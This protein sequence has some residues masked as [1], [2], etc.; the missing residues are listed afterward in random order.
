MKNVKFVML[1]LI[2]ALAL[3]L[4]ACG[5]STPKETHIYDNAKIVDVMNGPGTSKIGESSVIKAASSDITIEVLEDWYYN[6]VKTHNYNSCVIVYSDNEGMGVF[7]NVSMLVEKDV[8][9]IAK[10]DGSYTLGDTSGETLYYN[11]DGHLEIYE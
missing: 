7:T 9:L 5:S 11:A 8:E 4:C 6:Y 3:M 10:S 1:A 2:L